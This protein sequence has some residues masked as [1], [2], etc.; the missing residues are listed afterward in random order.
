MK[1]TKAHF[2]NLIF[3]AMAALL[4]IPQTRLPI[5]VFINKGLALFAPATI[6]VAAQK[7]LN[8]MDWVLLSN[9]GET[10]NFKATRGKVVFVNFWATWCPPC[11]AE[12]PSMQKLYDDYKDTIEFV[13]ISDE[14]QNV[15]NQFL[16]KNGYTIKVYA[17]TTPYPEVFNIS[18]I[19]RTFL[20]DANGNVVIDKTGAANWNSATVRETIDGLLK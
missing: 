3:L 18:S 9:T 8:A 2:K 15:V 14:Q 11:I 6:D 5:Q 17:P 4:I 19:P 16:A 10:L 12:L 7:Q 13:F 20:I 1:F